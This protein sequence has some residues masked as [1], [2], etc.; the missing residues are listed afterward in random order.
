MSDHRALKAAKTFGLSPG[1]TLSLL[2]HVEDLKRAAEGRD[3][4]PSQAGLLDPQVAQALDAWTDA[5]IAEEFS[6][7]RSH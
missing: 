4:S 1:Q 7:L 5:W 6:R 2:D 3:E